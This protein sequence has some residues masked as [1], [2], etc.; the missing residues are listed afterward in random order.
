MTISIYRGSLIFFAASPGGKKSELVR[1]F[2]MCVVT[3][4]FPKTSLEQ[5]RLAQ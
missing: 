1:Y 4:F 2:L 5:P 3:V